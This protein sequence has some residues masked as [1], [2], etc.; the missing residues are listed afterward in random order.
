MYTL[1]SQLKVYFGQNIIII[2]LQDKTA[3]ILLTILH[4]AWWSLIY[5]LPYPHATVL[6]QCLQINNFNSIF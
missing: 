4:V 5:L 3:L 2:V 1:Y 6:S